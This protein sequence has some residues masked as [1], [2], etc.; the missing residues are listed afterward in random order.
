LG[1]DKGVGGLR[2]LSFL[3]RSRLKQTNF[4]VSCI[5]YIEIVIFK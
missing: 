5:M 2:S 4:Q 3:G 1:R